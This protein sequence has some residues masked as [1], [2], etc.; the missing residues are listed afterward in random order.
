MKAIAYGNRPDTPKYSSDFKLV[1]D[2]VIG[3]RERAEFAANA[4]KHLEDYLAAPDGT[5]YRSEYASAA[6]SGDD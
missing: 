2:A 3:R 1:M 5:I 6:R 4:A